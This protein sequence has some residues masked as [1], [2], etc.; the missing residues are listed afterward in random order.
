MKDTGSTKGLRFAALCRVSTDAQEREGGSLTTQLA[1]IRAAVASVGGEVVAVYEG[2]EHG[3]PGSDR[4]V[5]D[6]LLADAAAGRFDAVCVTDQKRWDR[7]NDRS[8]AALLA[9]RRAGV[10]YFVLAAEQDL[11]NRNTLLHLGLISLLGEHEAGERIER[12][13]ATRLRRAEAGLPAVGKRPWGRVWV[14]HDKHS[15]HWELDPRLLKSE[16]TR[17]DAIVAI[18]AA[19]CRGTPLKALAVEH[20]VALSSLTD[21]LRD[22]CGDTW[23]FTLKDERGE[24]HTF[25][26]TVPRLLP[27]ATIAAVRARMTANRTRLN[28]SGSPRDALLGGYLFCGRCG[29]TMTLQRRPS[30][31]TYYRHSLWGV[32]DECE[33][34]TLKVERSAERAVV[35]KLFSLFGDAAAREEALRAALPDC[36]EALRRRGRLAAELVKAEAEKAN[37]VK[38]VAKGLLSDD[39]VRNAR[40]AIAEEEAR[41]RPEIARL[42][43]ELASVP[44]G[45]GF[46]VEWVRGDGPAQVV[47]EVFQRDAGGALWP[48]GPDDYVIASDDAGDQRP[49]GNTLVDGLGLTWR[50]R[51]RLVELVFDA[52]APM[53]DGRPAGAYVYGDRSGRTVRIEIVGRFPGRHGVELPGTSSSAG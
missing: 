18:A 4:P 31:S 41:L 46:A 2:S 15:G 36:G 16:L 29:Y 22:G 33:W 48:L 30:G 20:G 9:L 10:R 53:P 42:D 23:S 49:G 3:M 50:R 35:H 27:E 7:D 19:Y 6:R 39:D 34:R 24:P 1:A 28:A 14:R 11:W 52:A 25:T 38:A 37:L 26:Q 32:A 43:A 45:E 12:A 8:K 21:V 47:N 51:R 13:Q 40:R 5:F 44:G 17:A